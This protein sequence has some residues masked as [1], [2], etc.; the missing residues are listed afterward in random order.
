MKAVIASAV[1]LF[2]SLSTGQTVIDF[3][4]TPGPDG[5]LGTA[6]DVPTTP[7]QFILDEYQSVGVRFHAND[8]LG[9][10]TKPT[11]NE[12]WSSSSSLSTFFFDLRADFVVPVSSLKFLSYQSGVGISCS[13]TMLRA[14]GSAIA[15]IL[16]TGLTSYEATEPVYS[17]VLSG[18]SQPPQ[19]WI[20]D[21]TFTPIPSPAGVT[22][23]VTLAPG[24]LR[25]G[26]RR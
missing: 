20:D 11:V 14:D 17:L 18:G 7:G 3:E 19:P 2:A 4:H 21:L 6:D 25:R 16:T 26:R 15:S 23:A 12:F 24:L 8:T 22:V 5:L 13:A 1:C 10:D 9:F